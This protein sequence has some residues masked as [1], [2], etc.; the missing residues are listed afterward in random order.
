MRRWKQLVGGT[1]Y[2]SASD[3]RLLF[4]LGTNETVDTIEVKWPSGQTSTIKNVK[5]NQYI[6]IKE[7]VGRVA[8]P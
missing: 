8:K 5:A 4:G 1:S 3:K 6:T 2:F 7:G